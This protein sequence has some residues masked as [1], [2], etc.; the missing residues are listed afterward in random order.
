M[1]WR[2]ASQRVVRSDLVVLGEPFLGELA[3]FGERVEQVGI[4]HLFAIGPIE[5][6]D[7][8]VLIGL[9]R[10]DEAQLDVLTPCT[11]PRI[12]S[13]RVRQVT[14]YCNVSRVAV[15]QDF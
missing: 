6:L 11:G 9:A 5:A 7:V 15:A 14:W 8:S 1:R 12:T 2:Q 13:V 4:E 3:H 10:L